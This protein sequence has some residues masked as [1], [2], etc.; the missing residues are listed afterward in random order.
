M[1]WERKRRGL[2]RRGHN[3]ATWHVLGRKWAA[4]SR[5]TTQN[6]CTA[7]PMRLLLRIMRLVTV[8]R[9]DVV[10]SAD[11]RLAHRDILQLFIA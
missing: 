9:L 4:P 6:T 11:N 1:S 5:V 7:A 2:E 8:V 3:E 10:G